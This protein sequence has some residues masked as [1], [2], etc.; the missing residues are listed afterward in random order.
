MLK[1]IRIIF[2]LLLLAFVAFYSKSQRLSAR[3]W[4]EPLGVVVYPIN[5]DGSEAVAQYIDSLEA[6]DFKSIDRFF[7]SEAEAFELGLLQPTRLRLGGEIFEIPPKPPE[8]R[9][10]LEVM[11]WSLRLRYWS[12]SRAEESSLWNNDQVQIFVLYHEPAIDRV[13]AHSLGLAKGLIGVV[14]AFSGDSH[15]AKNNIVIAHELLHTVGA[16]DKYDEFGRPVYPRGF[17]EPDKQPLYPQTY[18]EIMAGRISLSSERAVMPTSLR[19]CGINYETAV[20][21]NWLQE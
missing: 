21:I 5:A 20:E 10:I 12:Y 13:L 6:D 16:T 1:I 7:E 4:S 9:M 11:L 18:A 14:Q 3:S 8:S 2:L 15:R 17:A 19:F